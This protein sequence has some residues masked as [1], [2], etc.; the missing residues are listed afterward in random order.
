MSAANRFLISVPTAMPVGNSANAT[1]KVDREAAER[2]ARE[3]EARRKTAQMEY[4]QRKNERLLWQFINGEGDAGNLTTTDLMQCLQ[5]LQDEIFLR[6][7]T[8]I[9]LKEKVLELRDILIGD[10]TA[11]I[12][13][14]TK[15]QK[16]AVAQ[17]KKALN[18]KKKVL[19]K[20]SN[21]PNTFER[22]VWKQI[23]EIRDNIVECATRDFRKDARTRGIK[24]EH[25]PVPTLK[26]HINMNPEAMKK[27]LLDH[28]E[29]EEDS[30]GSSDGSSDDDEKRGDGGG[31]TK[32]NPPKFIKSFV[33][34]GDDDSQ[35]HMTR[36]E[37]Q[38]WKQK[39]RVENKRSWDEAKQT[40]TPDE[41]LRDQPSRYKPTF[42]TAGS[43]AVDEYYTNPHV[44]VLKKRLRQIL[45]LWDYWKEVTS[46]YQNKNPLIDRMI[47]RI[48][49]EVET[50]LNAYERKYKKLQDKE[51]KI[52]ARVILDDS[53][54]TPGEE[55]DIY[56][57][58]YGDNGEEEWVLLTNKVH[59]IPEFIEIEHLEVKKDKKWKT[60]D[61]YV[62][63]MQA[64]DFKSFK[65]D[66]KQ[67]GK[68]HVTMI[69]EDDPKLEQYIQI[70]MN[71]NSKNWHIERH[72][73]LGEDEEESNDDYNGAGDSVGSDSNYSSDD[74]SSD[75]DSSDEDSSEDEVEKNERLQAERQEAER[76]DQLEKEI[77]SREE[78]QRLQLEKE[79]ASRE[80]EQRLAQVA[81]RAAEL[82]RLTEVAARRAL[83]ARLDDNADLVEQVMRAAAVP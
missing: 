82:Q 36:E 59:E 1:R 24:V 40:E 70:H 57:I 42:H 48:R 22:H 14:K 38:A 77:A 66:K 34:V 35:K 64:R 33:D 61:R 23:T 25:I 31:A 20:T 13:M 65:L 9:R 5:F 79:I 12:K 26:E 56:W 15:K 58:E 11:L 78:E 4:I 54:F 83:R 76:Q 17:K 2:R 46:V 74:D 63:S 55:I 28:D 53:E 72:C 19:Q 37:R 6:S 69:P 80:E 44:Y 50:K 67:R 68:L 41:R 18:E 49:T 30:D 45:K 16:L 7:I 43:K 51:L 21:K 62:F 32:K 39:E 8:D 60:M 3:A 81:A 27:S 71:V 73:P 75:D 47:D 10:A 52:T 29:R